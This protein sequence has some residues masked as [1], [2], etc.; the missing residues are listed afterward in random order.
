M[1]TNSAFCA[2]PYHMVKSRAKE[3]GL[4]RTETN[5]NWEADELAFCIASYAK[6][7]KLDSLVRTMR[8]RGWHR[9]KSAILAMMDREKQKRHGSAL[10]VNE[11]AQALGIDEHVVQAWVAKGWLHTT[12][13]VSP[14]VRLVAQSTLRN[15]IIAHP[16]EAAKG[17][18]NIVWLVAL[19]TDVDLAG[20]LRRPRRKTVHATVDCIGD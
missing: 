2:I 5:Q 1:D 15:F 8:R 17:Y 13:H 10:T 18:P 12:T 6:G 11:V 9:S 16:W 3:L 7:T 19:L 4:V 20:S 14:H